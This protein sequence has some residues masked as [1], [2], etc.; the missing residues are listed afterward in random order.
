MSRTNWFYVV[1]SLW[2]VIIFATVVWLAY[3]SCERQ[4]GTLVRGLFWFEC[5]D[6]Q[7]LQEIKK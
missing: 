1:G 7:K 5:V 3:S 4:G 6:K 2:V